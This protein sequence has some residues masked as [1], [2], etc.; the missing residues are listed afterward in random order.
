[1]SIGR[2][3][4]NLNAYA[5]RFVLSLRVRVKSECLDR[6]VPAWV[7]ALHHA[8]NEH[9]AHYQF[10]RKHQGIVNNLVF[11]QGDAE[12]DSGKPIE[13]RERLGR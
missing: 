1:V 5:E 6:M 10:E 9:V 7:G 2:I 11:R 13:C 8:L 4:P 3:T 12:K